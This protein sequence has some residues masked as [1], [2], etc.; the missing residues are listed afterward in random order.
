MVFASTNRNKFREVQPILVQ[1]GIDVEFAQTEL[2][3]I[4]SDSLEEIATDKA[5]SAYTQVRK[6]VIV[7]D[8]GLFISGLGGFPGQYSS[9]VFR[10]IGNAGILRLL[11]DKNDRSAFFA[12][13]I[14][15]SDGKDVMIFEGR[16]A[17]KIAEQKAK[18]G[19]GYDPIFVPDGATHTYAELQNKNEYSH[20]K[21][22]LDLFAERYLSL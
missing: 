2:T 14:A 10:T 19:W 8:D 9:Y 15:F 7:E 11:S 13:L 12:S 4:Q 5:V 18:G 22:A 16:V 6:P 21:K 20:R 3:E 17:G 1:H